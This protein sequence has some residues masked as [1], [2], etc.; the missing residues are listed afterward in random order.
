MGMRVI[1]LGVGRF[2]VRALSQEQSLKVAVIEPV[3]DWPT[4]AGDGGQFDVL[5]DHTLGYF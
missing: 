5:G 4:D 2:L 1:R 3:R